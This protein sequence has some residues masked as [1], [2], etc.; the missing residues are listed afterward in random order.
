[1]ATEIVNFEAYTL[2]VLDSVNQ[3]GSA[4]TNSFALKFETAKLYGEK[5]N[6][7]SM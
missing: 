6:C 2:K 4:A 3:C 7:F 5:N 1:M